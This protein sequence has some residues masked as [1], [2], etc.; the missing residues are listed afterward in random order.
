MPE[1]APDNYDLFREWDAHQ[2]AL[3]VERR[4]RERRAYEEAEREGKKNE[5]VSN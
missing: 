2:E 3:R 5:F 1:Y 4:I